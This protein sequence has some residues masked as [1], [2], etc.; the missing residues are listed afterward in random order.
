MSKKSKTTKNILDW[1]QELG[2]RIE[3][4]QICKERFDDRESSREI[5]ATKDIEE[6]EELCY[7]PSVLLLTETHAKESVIGQSLIGNIE[8]LDEFSGRYPH[9][10]ELVCMAIFMVYEKFV[11]ISSHWKPYLDSLPL[12]Y[13]LPICWEDE[14]L[15]LLEGTNLHSA[16]VKRKE[17]LN[18]VT[19]IVQPLLL[20]VFGHKLRYDELL[21]GYCS[22]L[23]RAFP[24]A[25]NNESQSEM[26]R[27][28]WIELSEICMYPALDMLNHDRKAQIDW[29]PTENGVSFVS[30]QSFQ[31]GKPLFLSYGPKGNENLL[32]NYGFVLQENPEDYYKIFLNVREE[33]PLYETR[34]RILE[35]LKLKRDYMLFMN[36]ENLS[37]NLELTTC[38]LISNR[39]ELEQLEQTPQFRTNRMKFV[40]WHTLWCLMNEKLRDIK[41]VDGE[42]DPERIELANTYRNGQRLILEY[43]IRL[44]EKQAVEL[45]AKDNT[46]LTLL[47][48]E[49]PSLDV[50]YGSRCIVSYQEL[51]QEQIDEDTMY[52][53]HLIQQLSDETA[54]WNSPLRRHFDSVKDIGR[55]LG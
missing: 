17:W 46:Q 5:V 55:I 35:K 48:L 18:N 42:F 54:A 38:I 24:K 1:A 7:I 26:K 39:A 8:H 47:N 45:L 36:D 27:T 31:K 52:C 3:N 29:I 22:I 43:S 51:T 37:E 6:G 44:I 15:K 25:R 4:F 34:I 2:A 50:E 19:K 40:M 14:D 30:R 23:S 12:K 11:N 10:V 41:S 28:D 21:W 13:N 33:D 16:T 20:E 32:G 53:I 49:H 9:A